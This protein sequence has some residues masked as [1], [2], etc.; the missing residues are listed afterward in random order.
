MTKQMMNR[1]QILLT[2]MLCGSANAQWLNY[3]DPGVPRTDDGKAYLSAPAP[4][5]NGRPDLT[6]VWMHVP[7]P[8]DELRRLYKGTFVEGELDVLPPGMHLELQNKY[9]FNL[10]IDFES[11][12]AMK[13]G[14]PPSG[15]TPEGMAVLQR[16]SARFAA[17]PPSL[18]QTELVGWPQVGLLSE[19]IKIVQA[20]KETLVLYE[21]GNL[22]REIYA[23]GRTFP[24]SFELPA[25]LGY[26]VGRWDGDVFVVETRG[27]QE[28]LLDVRGHPRS[29]AMHITERFHR[30][31][32]GHLDVEMTFDDPI[33][34]AEPFTVRIAHDLLPDSDIFEMFCDN[35]KDAEH[36]MPPAP[37]RLPEPGGPPKP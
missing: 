6:G 27:F 22:H 8:P 18:C 37:P 11:P 13:P 5:L 14:A 4:R 2:V 25:R 19:P 23:D 15:V 28:S 16:I 26:S 34:Y 36:M 33:V 12:E 24:A 17:K 3:R 31:D 9:G 7:T 30:R 35:E 1:W 21:V 29:E 10:R 32:F 20:P